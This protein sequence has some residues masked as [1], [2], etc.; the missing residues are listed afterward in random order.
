MSDSD[1][2]TTD[3]LHE[4]LNLTTQR[5]LEHKKSTDGTFII[6]DE[7]GNVQAVPAKDVEL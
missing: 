1:K 2:I 5:L 4:G 7:Q 3:K 6:A